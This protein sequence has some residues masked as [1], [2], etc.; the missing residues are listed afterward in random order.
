MLRF[1]GR[2][3]ME[4]PFDLVVGADGAWSKVRGWL[5]G[6]MPVYSGV[7]GYEMEIRELASTCPGVDAMIGEG[8]VFWF[9]GSEDIE[10]AE[11]GEQ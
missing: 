8:D 2:E 4:G 9:V 7:S 3:E 10:C 6:V 1:D 5:S 11:D